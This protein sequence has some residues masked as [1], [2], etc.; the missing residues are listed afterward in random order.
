[1]NVYLNLLLAAAANLARYRLRSVVVMICLVAICGPYVTG[2]AISEGIRA[3]AEVAVQEGADLYLTLDYFGRN[4][5]VPLKYLKAFRASPHVTAVVPRIVGRATAEQNAAETEEI[6][7]EL[8]VILGLEPAQMQ[9]GPTG[10]LTPPTGAAVASEL[11]DGEV[12]IGSALADHFGLQ[13]GQQITLR[14]ADVTMPL[15]VAAVLPRNATIW[16][17]Q[18]VCMNLEDAGKLFALPGYASDFL[19]YCR[20][21]PGNIQAVREAT[22]EILGDIPYRLQTKQGEVASYVDKGFRHQQ[23]IFTVLFLVAFA[24]GIPAL[25]I[26]SGVGLAERNRE[27]G[28]CKAV[29]WQTSDVMLMVMFEQALLSAI[30]ACLAVLASYVWVRMFNGVVIAQFFIGELGHIAP[31]KVPARFA[32][33]P[34]ALALLLCLAITMVG[35]LFTTWRLAVRPPAESIR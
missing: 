28:I 9:L 8:V 16:S 19:I 10:W 30:A 33:V 11:H 35:G 5:P 29:G 32:P 7:A 6:D 1:V 22:L 13:R 20:P 34:A 14:V 2:I 24:V 12:M 15:H 23:G 3:E 26:A 31:F 4:G 21:G 17:A 18:L 27:I 25:L